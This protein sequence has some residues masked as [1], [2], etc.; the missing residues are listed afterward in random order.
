M[1]QQVVHRELSQGSRKLKRRRAAAAECDCAGKLDRQ[2]VSVKRRLFPG[3]LALLAIV[4]GFQR[5][6]VELQR[7]KQP[8]GEIEL[9]TIGL[10]IARD[11][12]EPGVLPEEGELPLC[13][14]RDLLTLDLSSVQ[15]QPLCL[16]IIAALGRYL[17]E[18]QRCL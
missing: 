6:P 3:E 11:G 12:G 16:Q 5:Q 18:D 1:S 10:Q 4:D 2:R 7:L 13:V 17:V 15:L 9:Q 8:V 14:C